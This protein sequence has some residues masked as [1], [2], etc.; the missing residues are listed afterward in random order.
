MRGLR[1]PTQ[2]QLIDAGLDITGVRSQVEVRADLQRGVLW[3]NVD[4]VCVLRICRLESQQ[5]QIAPS[6]D[7]SRSSAE[8]DRD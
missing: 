6:G 5:L 3:V 1:R 8:E 2:D 4:G 7:A